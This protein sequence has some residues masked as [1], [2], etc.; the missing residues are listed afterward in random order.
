LMT[1]Y[2]KNVLIISTD[3]AHNLS[4]AYDQKFTS[5]PTQVNGFENL[6]A[7]EID[8]HIDSEKIKL[9]DLSGY[10][11]D[12]EASKGFI[13]DLV[14]SVPG[15]DEA[16]S[17]AELINSI[18]KSEFDLVIFDTAP[19]GHTLRLLNFPNLIE[20]GLEKLLTIKQKFHGMVQQFSGMFG[21]NLEENFNKV[22][23]NME[24]MKKTA[25]K[26]NEQMKDKKRTTFVAVCIP[27]FLS[28]YE[29]DRL[30]QELAK[31]NIDIH[32]IVINQVLYPGDQC[33]M[34][35][36]RHKMQKKNIWIK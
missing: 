25:E 19:T 14:S 33:K 28:M 35:V 27:E 3:P 17:F 16:M 5:T 6:F 2:R 36:S 15:I 13:A 8:P 30:I 11:E 24:I 9:P 20:K 21:A 26:V 23:A 1:Q 10:V 4:D 18:E 22:F 34:C 7:M 31:Y 32:N 29:T 12:A